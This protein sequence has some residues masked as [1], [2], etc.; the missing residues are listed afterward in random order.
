M[1]TPRP[2]ERFSSRWAHHLDE[3]GVGSLAEIFEGDPP[4][5]P[6]GC[7]AQAWSVSE[8]LRA[9]M[10]TARERPRVPGT[11]PRPPKAGGRHR[12]ER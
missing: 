5:R 6:R 10:E 12:P 9:W 4:F 7:V 11:P 8:S 3:F 2:R 1:V